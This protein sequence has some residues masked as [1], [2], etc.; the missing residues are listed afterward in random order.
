MDDINVLSFVDIM[1]SIILG[2]KFDKRFVISTHYHQFYRLMV[3]KFRFMNTRV[4][5]VD[6]YNGNGPFIS[7]YDTLNNSKEL[8]LDYKEFN[9]EINGINKNSN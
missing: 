9:E 7:Y 5:R 3:K 4:F 6:D 8:L 2:E 1:R